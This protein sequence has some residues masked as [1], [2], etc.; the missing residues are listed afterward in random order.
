[1][2]LHDVAVHATGNVRHAPAGRHGLRGLVAASMLS[3]L[4]A[5]AVPATAASAS[6]PSASRF[7]GTPTVGALFIAGLYP[8][9]I[10]SASVVRSA[11]RS[12]VLTAAHC[13]RSGTAN[14]YQFAPGYHAGKAP[15]GMWR[16]TA[17][18]GAPGWIEH[19]NNHDDFAFLVVAPRMID[20]RMRHLQDVTGGNTLGVTP[21][22]GRRVTIIGYPLGVAGSPLRC[23]VAVFRQGPFTGSHCHGFGD[24]TS[25]GPWLATGPAPRHVVGL[26]G[27]LHQ[28]GCT[29]ETTYSPPLGRA[30]H[31]ALYR[32]AHY[33]VADH[34]PAPPGSGC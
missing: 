19:Y 30:A 28:G 6:D 11:N 32:A 23:T 29:T 7:S 24:G 8:L 34:V 13:V 16:V 4:L 9:H 10:C 21:N 20:G 27:G 31:R 18:Y 14:G 3:A 15:F 22:A 33:R 1:M 2:V 5:S 26:I 17:A 12:V 25:G